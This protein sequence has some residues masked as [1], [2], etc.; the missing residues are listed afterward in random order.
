MAAVCILYSTSLNRFYVGSCN[1]LNL[2][3]EQ[4]SRKEHPGSFTTKAEDWELYL[5]VDGLDGTQARK[6]E[7][8]I[9]KM[10]SRKYIENLKM[11]PEMVQKLQER[12][13]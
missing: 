11:Y 8:H 2:R 3:L 4:H 7:N 5:S 1:D 12:Y 9:K 6:I 10:K 13:S